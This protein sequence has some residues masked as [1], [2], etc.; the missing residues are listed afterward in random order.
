MTIKL[1]A[2]LGNNE[3]Q[4]RHT[5]HNVGFEWIDQLAEKYNASWQKSP[6]GKGTTSKITLE[7]NSIS[8]FKPGLLMNINGRPIAD[9]A[10]YFKIEPS[11]ILLVYDDLDLKTGIIKCRKSEGHGGHNGVRDLGHHLDIKQILRLKIGIDRPTDKS[12]T[13]QYVLQK[14]NEQ[15]YA[16][17]NYAITNSIAHSNLL[18]SQKINAYC[19]QLAVANQQESSNGI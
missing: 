3:E 11:E 2:A 13:S 8:L 18:L 6:H 7:S 19:E 12:K 1:I 15:A 17:I 9:F 5:R 4:Y 10:R 14:P 16:R